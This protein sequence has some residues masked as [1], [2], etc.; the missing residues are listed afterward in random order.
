MTTQP[1]TP[2][3]APIRRL[4]AP[5]RFA[6]CRALALSPEPLTDAHVA[7]R[8][9]LIAREYARAAERRKPH[10]QKPLLGVA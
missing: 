8:R 3:D 7:E 1:Q 10:P 4:S 5:E 6:E 2:P 9:R